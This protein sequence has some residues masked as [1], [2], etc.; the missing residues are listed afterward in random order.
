MA[1]KTAIDAGTRHAYLACMLTPFTYRDL[2]VWK[3]GINLVGVVWSDQSVTPGRCVDT[4]QRRGRP[5]Q[6]QHEGV[7]EP[8]QHRD[9][10]QP[11]SR[12]QTKARTAA[13]QSQRLMIPAP[14]P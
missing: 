5:R 2:V 12:P 11:P 1:G 8:R 7:L 3:L 14:N 10:S 13:P 4:G 6:T 9:G